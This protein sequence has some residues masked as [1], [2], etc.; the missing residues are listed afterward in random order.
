MIGIVYIAREAH[1]PQKWIICI[2]S[3]LIDRLVEKN[4]LSSLYGELEILHEVKKIK[5]CI[6]LLEFFYD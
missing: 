1:A 3:M 6:R 4:L 2:K 5:G